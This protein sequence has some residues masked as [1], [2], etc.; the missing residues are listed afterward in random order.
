MSNPIIAIK[1][2]FS[3]M[4]ENH[5]TGFFTLGSRHYLSNCSPLPFLLMSVL[6]VS[7]QK[8]RQRKPVES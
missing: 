8:V 6:N 4:D 5:N 1:K 7:E 2:D 3:L